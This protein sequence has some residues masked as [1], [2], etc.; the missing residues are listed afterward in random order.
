M[1]YMDYMDLAVHCPEK[2][3]YI[4]S[5]TKTIRDFLSTVVTTKSQSTSVEKQFIEA[6]KEWLNVK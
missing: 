3:S 6:V 2:G 4:Y 1:A 5:L